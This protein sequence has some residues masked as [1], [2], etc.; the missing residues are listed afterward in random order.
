V[1]T[2]VSDPAFIGPYYASGGYVHDNR[3]HI[4][5][6]VA[7]GN[8]LADRIAADMNLADSLH[9]EPQIETTLALHRRDGG[10]TIR[11][12]V[13]FCSG[14]LPLELHAAIAHGKSAAKLLGL[15]VAAVLPMRSRP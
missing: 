5:C 1:S 6:G 14:A 15:Q 9:A 8:D 12:S 2:T 11:S 4:V 10:E 3:G 13:E 7:G